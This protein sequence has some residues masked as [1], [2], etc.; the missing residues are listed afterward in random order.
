MRFSIP[1]PPNAI[2]SPSVVTLPVRTSRTCNTLAFSY[3]DPNYLAVGLDKVRGDPSLVIW[4]IETVSSGLSTSSAPHQGAFS[5]PQPLLPRSVRG[6]K[7]TIQQWAH[8]EVVTSL[9]FLPNTT[10]LLVAGVSHRWLRLFDLRNS[11]SPTNPLT[12]ATKSV[13]G[14]SVDPFDPNRIACFGEDGA[15]R[16]WDY[17]WF[18]SPILTF[19]ERDA[20]ADGANPRGTTAISGIEFS[21]SRRG[22]IATIQKDAVQVRFWDTVKATFP[23]ECGMPAIRPD[24]AHEEIHASKISKLA[25]LPWSSPAAEPQPNPQSSNHAATR[26]EQ[27]ILHNTR[28]CKS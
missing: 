8:A 7:S 5:R 9:A 16:V 24:G 20:V 13:H 21:N 10:S 17:R 27:L 28:T 18:G 3:L 1:H 2:R 25:R 11:S 22:T 4:D 14:I 26:G 19:T 15:V 23:E 6:D 12:T